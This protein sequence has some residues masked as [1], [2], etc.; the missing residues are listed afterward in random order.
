MHFTTWPF[1][2]EFQEQ[3]RCLFPF[4]SVFLVKKRRAR[5]VLVQR[6]LRRGVRPFWPSLVPLAPRRPGLGSTS[7]S[8]AASPLMVSR[9]RRQRTPGTYF[10]ETRVLEAFFGTSIFESQDSGP[11]TV[12]HCRARWGQALS[13]HQNGRQEAQRLR[14]GSAPSSGPGLWLTRASGS[15]R[16]QRGPGRQRWVGNSALGF[17]GGLGLEAEARERRAACSSGRPRLVHTRCCFYTFG[18]N[19]H[20]SQGTSQSARIYFPLVGFYFKCPLLPTLSTAP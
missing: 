4:Q 10:S 19:M 11:Q 13:G 3:L 1:R 16:V 8:R 18:T 5:C 14:H 9:V 12:G 7:G 17:E 2:P 20:R 15:G 6:R